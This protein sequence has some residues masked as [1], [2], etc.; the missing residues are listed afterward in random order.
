MMAFTFFSTGWSPW[1]STMCPNY[2]ATFC[3]KAHLLRFNL[4]PAS[5][6][7]A[8]HLVQFRRWSVPSTLLTK[9][10]SRCTATRGIPFRRFFIVSLHFHNL[11]LWALHKKQSRY[12]F[13]ETT[14]N[15]KYW[16]LVHRHTKQSTKQVL[17]QLPENW[18]VLNISIFKHAVFKRTKNCFTYNKDDWD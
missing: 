2:L 17:H 12:S 15:L 8:Q 9:M 13:S 1:A 16:K 18:T 11:N 5:L 14:L 4:K 10:S 7:T 3:M 6:K